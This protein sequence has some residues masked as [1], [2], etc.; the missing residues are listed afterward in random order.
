MLGRV[1]FGSRTWICTIA[2]PAL[3][4]SIA[5]T[6]I[7]PGVTGTARLRAGVS[8]DPVMAQLSMT[9]RG[10]SSARN[11]LLS[12][13]SSLDAQICVVNYLS[14]LRDLALDAGA[15]LFRFVRYGF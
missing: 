6:A 15:E 4:A 10:I 12:T 1:V 13:S 8:A 9:L 5:D 14:P 11:L 2:A 7:S 3:A